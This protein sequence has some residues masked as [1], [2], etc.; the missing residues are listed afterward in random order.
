MN[1]YNSKVCLI[2]SLLKFRKED[3]TEHDFLE[4]TYSTFHATNIVMQKQNRAHN[5]M[6]LSNLIYVLTLAEKNSHILMKNHQER[7]T[8]SSAVLEAHV[9]KY[10][11]QN[12]LNK[13]GR[14]NKGSISKPA[15]QGQK[16]KD[17]SKGGNSTP[18]HDFLAPKASNFKN[19][20]KD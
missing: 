16:G 11:G 9:N 3:L 6:R 1:E 8:S 20:S 10:R 14:N 4:N 13:H 17:P 12:Q 2:R 15:P 5:F 18:K 19:K 7:P